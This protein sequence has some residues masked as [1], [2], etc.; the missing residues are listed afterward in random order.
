MTSIATPAHDSNTALRDLLVDAHPL[1][2][3]IRRV[4]D[5]AYCGFSQSRRVGL[6]A[7]SLLLGPMAMLGIR[8]V[9]EHRMA[10]QDECHIAVDE[11]LGRLGS[12]LADRRIIALLLD[13][14]PGRD[15]RIAE[16]LRRHLEL[17]D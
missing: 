17:A 2:N 15:Q 10:Q 14:Y 1:A 12:S 8:W 16:K 7:L 13:D 6:D 5:T 11:L 9:E 4:L 3:H